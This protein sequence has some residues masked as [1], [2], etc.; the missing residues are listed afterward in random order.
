MLDLREADLV[1]RDDLLDRPGARGRRRVVDPADPARLLPRGHPVRR[2]AAAARHRPQRAERPARPVGGGRGSS[3]G[4][5]TRSTLPATSTSSPARAPTSRRS[6]TRCATGATA[7][8][9]PTAL[10]CCWCTTT[11]ARPIQRGG[12]LLA[13][14]VSGC[15]SG[16][17]T[18]SRRPRIRTLRSSST[19]DPPADPRCRGRRRSAMAVRLSA[20]GRDERGRHA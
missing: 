7:T 3:S 4:A 1:L 2:L 13:C 16:T 10:R 15:G 20:R 14:A 12:P 9:R 19:A 11:A 6:S 18:W 17:C 8:R 5:S